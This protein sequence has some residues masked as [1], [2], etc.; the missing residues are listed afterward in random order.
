MPPRTAI[1]PL[2]A[3]DEKAFIA[4]ASTS[5]KLHRTW[6]Y[7][8]DNGPDFRRNLARFNDREHFCFVVYLPATGAL[9]GVITLTHIVTGAL[10]SGFLGYYAFAG[11]EKRG[12]MARG[13]RAVIRHAFGK[14]KLHRM[15]A[16]I[17]P[18]NTASIA[19]ARACGFKLEGYSPRYLK[20][21]GRW[22]DH[23]R[24]AIVRG[25]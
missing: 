1:R 10:R 15:E 24:W 19:L 22:R 8:P 11:L 16:N 25:G 6:V 3:A 7:A 13:M 4:A 21:G 2:T 9:A 18:Q 12:H 14:L 5:R 20:I 23:E 17:Q